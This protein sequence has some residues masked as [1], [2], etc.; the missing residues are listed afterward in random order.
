[1]HILQDLRPSEKAKRGD[2]L[3]KEADELLEQ[4]KDVTDQDNYYMARSLLT[5]ARDF[6]YG[7]ETKNVVHRSQQS[8][9]Y[10]GKAHETLQTVQLVTQESAVKTRMWDDESDGSAV[11]IERQ[12]ERAGPGTDPDSESGGAAS[13]HDAVSPIAMVFPAALTATA[14]VPAPAEQIVSGLILPPSSNN[15]SSQVLPPYNVHIVPSQLSI[16]SFSQTKPS[17]NGTLA[18]P[19]LP[20][21]PLTPATE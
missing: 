8:R 15:R 1:M 3:L 13:Y 16:D 12:R 18:A 17:I 21:P 4:R 11:P 14:Q 6:R 10:L 7:M 9:L 2:K 19:S 5:S 20:T